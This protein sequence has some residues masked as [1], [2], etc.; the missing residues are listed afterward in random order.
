VTTN[1]AGEVDSVL[2]N[3]SDNILTL[4]TDGIGYINQW[5]FDKTYTR[6][7][8]IDQDGD[9]LDSLLV[10]F[11]PTSFWSVGKSCCMDNQEFRTKGFKIKMLLNR[12][13]GMNIDAKERELVIMLAETYND[14]PNP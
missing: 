4:D 9:N 8:V 10:G 3:G 2:S 13:C 12:D 14:L 6:T 5:T 11:N 1:Y 7:I